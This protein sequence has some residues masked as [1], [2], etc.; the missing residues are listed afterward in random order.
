MVDVH[1][2]VDSTNL[3]ALRD[4][5]PWRVVVADHQ[6]A[7]RG[8]L[9]RQ[10]L[11]PA[12]TSIAVSVVVPAPVGRTADLG[13]LPLLS[14][15]AMRSALA[16]VAHVAGRL[17]WPNDV[18]V[19]G[20]ARDGSPGPRK[21]G[22]LLAERVERAVVVGIGVNTDL[23]ADELP[24]GRATS[25]WL[26]GAHVARETLVVDIL[27]ALRHRYAA[28]QGA[29]G[30]AA[31]SGLA[32]AYTGR[33][34]T[35]G[36]EVRAQLPGHRVV[37]GTAVDIDDQGRTLFRQ[38]ALFHPQGPAGGLY[39]AM[40]Y[41][42]HGLVFGGMQRNIAHEAEKVP[43]GGTPPRRPTRAGRRRGSSP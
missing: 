29:A 13:W 12:G 18:V 25:T 19:D 17:K 22:G 40:I 33:C 6:S 30:D 1:V 10:W 8:R 36:R 42:F 38:R 4:P 27:E 16:D 21:L 2:S 3:E 11:A 31:R 37:E 9:A 24:V 41:P 39:W 35:L 32:A 26:E 28:W 15:M 5:R 20:P 23:R 7:G 43:P 34:L 14:G